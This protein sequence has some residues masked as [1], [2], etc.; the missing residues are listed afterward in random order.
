VTLDTFS[1]LCLNPFILVNLPEQLLEL[2]DE[3]INLPR[4]FLTALRPMR[5]AVSQQHAYEQAGYGTIEEELYV[6][7]LGS[8]PF[9]LTTACLLSRLGRRSLLTTV[10]RLSPRDLERTA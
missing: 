10:A 4:H 2:F 8:S 9:S 3:V 1:A 6:H 7:T 5:E